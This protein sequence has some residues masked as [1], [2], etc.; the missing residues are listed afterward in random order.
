MKGMP[1]LSGTGFLGTE[2]VHRYLLGGSFTP[3]KRPSSAPLC[4]E[5]RPW[6]HEHAPST[7][8][9]PALSPDDRS[10]QGPR[11]RSAL[12]HVGGGG[13]RGRSRGSFPPPEPSSGGRVPPG[14]AKPQAGRK[15]AAQRGG[16]EGGSAGRAAEDARRWR[17]SRVRVRGGL[18]AGAGGW[19]RRGPGEPGGAVRLRTTVQRGGAAALRARG[20]GSACAGAGS[21]GSPGALRP[22]LAAAPAA[23]PGDGGGEAPAG[24][25]RRPPARGRGSGAREPGMG[26]GG[27]GSAGNGLSGLSLSS[28]FQVLPKSERP[29]GNL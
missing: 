4:V 16:A 9:L 3:A 14:T 2:S 12:G 19:G 20:C 17:P 29:S 11:N 23:P 13:R 10:G 15:R 6:G 21:P 8:S 22:L 18:C 7:R 5:M 24:P 25:D 1:A 27:G 28:F 26:R